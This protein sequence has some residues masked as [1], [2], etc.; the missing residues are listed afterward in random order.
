[1]AAI[2]SEIQKINIAERSA[3]LRMHVSMTV[4]RERCGTASASSISVRG[5]AKLSIGLRVAIGV[6][7]EKLLAMRVIRLFQYSKC[8]RA[9]QSGV[10]AI[11]P[12]SMLPYPGAARTPI[13]NC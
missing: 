12:G 1:M 6:D 11:A 5:T 2:V 8:G 4:R 7:N 9:A 10:P 3:F 13:F